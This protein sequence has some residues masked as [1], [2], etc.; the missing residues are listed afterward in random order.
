MKV[1]DFSDFEDLSIVGR[2]VDVVLL[3]ATKRADRIHFERIHESNEVGCRFSVSFEKDGSCKEY[4]TDGESPDEVFRR[5]S[6]RPSEVWQ[7]ILRRLKVMANVVDDGPTI[8]ADGQILLRLSK[9]RT[10]EFYMTT[11]P[12]PY[13]DNK[14]TLIYKG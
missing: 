2:F 14:V 1:H 11:N 10:V 12:D 9:N 8:S 3:D 7:K 6:M 13:T 4:K 5:L